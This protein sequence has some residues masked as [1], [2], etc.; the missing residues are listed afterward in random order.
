MAGFLIMANGWGW[1]RV[2]HV[3]IRFSFILPIFPIFSLERY[4][5]IF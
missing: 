1:Q 2:I 4:G 5:M 3:N